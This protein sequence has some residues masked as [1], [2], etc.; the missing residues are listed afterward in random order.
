MLFERFFKALG[1]HFQPRFLR[2]LDG[3]FYRETE[4]VVQLERGVARYRVPYEMF[5]YRGEA[6][7]P[8]RDRLFKALFFG[9]YLPDYAVCVA[10]QFG[11]HVLVFVDDHFRDF[12]EYAR[13]AA[14]LF[15]ETYRAAQ[16]TA[17][18]IA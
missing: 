3:H 17:K 4:R 6:L 8:A 15:D 9:V 18:N 5:A 1:I 2:E 14:E 10:A 7:H 16:Q 11:I 13:A 12:A